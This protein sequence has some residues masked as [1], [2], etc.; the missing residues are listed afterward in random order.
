M[1]NFQESKNTLGNPKGPHNSCKCAVAYWPMASQ[2]ATTFKPLTRPMVRP[3]WPCYLLAPSNLMRVLMKWVTALPDHRMTMLICVS[4]C[5]TCRRS[6]VL[7]G[8]AVSRPCPIHLRMKVSLMSLPLL[9][10]PI[11]CN[12]ACSCSLTH[13]PKNCCKPQPIALDG[14]CISHP[15]KNLRM[16]IGCKGRAW[17]MPVM[18]TANGRVLVRLGQLGLLM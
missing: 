11:P 4:Q 10:M 3:P 5:M 1:C 2:L 6:C 15:K 14:K 7:R 16:A 13:A 18:F 12:T 17:P 8:C 9:R